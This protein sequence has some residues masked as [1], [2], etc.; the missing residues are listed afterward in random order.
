MEANKKIKSVRSI[1]KSLTRSEGK[2]LASTL[3]ASPVP[4]DMHDA[5]ERSNKLVRMWEG[6]GGVEDAKE[7]LMDL[8]FPLMEQHNSMMKQ[9]F[10]TS[11]DN[12]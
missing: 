8:V 6:I 7:G 3:L 2:L 4:T 11:S 12:D 1:L 5:E 9:A 10:S